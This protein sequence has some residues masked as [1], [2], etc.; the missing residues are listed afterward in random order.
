[1][2]RLRACFALIIY[3]YIGT[4]LFFSNITSDILRVKKIKKLCAR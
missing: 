3:I 2:H 4:F 1:M